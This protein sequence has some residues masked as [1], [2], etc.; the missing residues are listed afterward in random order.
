MEFP[1][2]G[3]EGVPPIRQNSLFFTKKIVSEKGP[4]NGFFEPFPNRKAQL[5][6]YR[7]EPELGR[8]QPQYYYV[9]SN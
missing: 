6:S 1:T 9:C 5:A 2:G 8:A 7:A 4:S 3:G